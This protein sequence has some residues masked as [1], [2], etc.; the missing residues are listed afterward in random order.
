ML[1]RRIGHTSMRKYAWMAPALVLLAFVVIFLFGNE[2]SNPSPVKEVTADYERVRLDTS[3]S[4]GDGQSFAGLA[5]DTR[6]TVLQRLSALRTDYRVLSPS[7]TVTG[8]TGTGDATARA[9][10]IGT[11]LSQNSLGSYVADAVSPGL[12]DD[13]TAGDTGQD[14]MIV[15]VRRTDKAIAHRLTAALAPM[16]SGTVRIQFDDTRRPGHLLAVIADTAQA[17][18][19]AA[20][21]HYADTPATLLA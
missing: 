7:I 4:H 6:Q 19:S 5:D 16:L 9:Q 10:R 14:G 1:R 15:F 18:A 3:T 21:L 8:M 2:S 17:S 12:A 13:G 11:L 20:R